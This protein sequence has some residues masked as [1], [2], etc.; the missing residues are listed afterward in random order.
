LYSWFALADVEWKEEFVKGDEWQ[1]FIVEAPGKLLRPED[2]LTV[3]YAR[4]GSVKEVVSGVG[5]AIWKL[6]KF[7][8]AYR[9]QVEKH[10]V[11]QAKDKLEIIVKEIL[12]IIDKLK[13]RGIKAEQVKRLLARAYQYTDDVLTTLALAQ[14]LEL[15]AIE[16]LAKPAR[17]CPTCKGAGSIP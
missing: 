9:L 14:K 6:V 12:P 2:A 7:L 1:N 11:K 15:E 16:K 17:S 5:S 8:A 13:Q 3:E 4:T 10:K